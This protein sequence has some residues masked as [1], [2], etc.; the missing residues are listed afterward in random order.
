MPLYAYRNTQ[1]KLFFLKYILNIGT[2]FKVT[3]YKSLVFSCSGK[4]SH[5]AI[6]VDL[7]QLRIETCILTLN[8]LILKLYSQSY[9]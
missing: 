3:S 4:S 2:F 1:M 6:D 9:F 5:A 8:G 7:K